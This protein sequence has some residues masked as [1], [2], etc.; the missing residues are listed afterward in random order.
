ML[1]RFY[2][3]PFRKDV[4]QTAQQTLGGRA[5]SLEQLGNL[6]TWMGF[7]GTLVDV[8]A[9]QLSPPLPLLCPAA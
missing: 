3:V 8:S 7:M 9:A 2:N 4:V 6:A 5:C 1:A